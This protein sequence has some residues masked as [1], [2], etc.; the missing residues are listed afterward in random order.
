MGIF[1]RHQRSDGVVDPSSATTTTHAGHVHSKEDSNGRLRNP[2]QHQSESG[3]LNSRPP[4]GQWLKV[5]WPDIL[6]MICMGAIG[7]GVYKAHPAPSRSFPV[8]FQDGEI[9]YPEFAYP[10]RKELIPIWAAAM[11][12]ALVP[13]AVIL[14]CQLRV[15]SFWDVNNAV[16]GLLYSLINAA[17]FQVFLKWL[18]G[19]LRP[20][21]LAVCKPEIPPNGIETGNGL[22]EIFYDRSIC[23]GDRTQIDDSLES[24]PSGHTTA[25]FAGFVFLSLYLNAKLKVFANYH[26]A[27]W[28]LI[29]VYAPIL[30]ATL[31][32]GAL[33]IDKFHNWYDCFAGAVIGTLMAFSAYR[34][35][36][37]SV[38]DFRFNHIPLTRAVPFSFGA[39]PLGAGG[40]ESAVWTRQAE[41]GHEDGAFGGAPFDSAHALRGLGTGGA[42]SAAG[43]LSG[44]HD[45]TM[46]APHTST[47]NGHHSGV[48]DPHH[49][50]A[51]GNPAGTVN[52]SQT[53]TMNEPHSG[54]AVGHHHGN[55]IDR[56]PVG[57]ATG[58]STVAG[59]YG[60]HN[61]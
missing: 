49:G 7:L 60:D 50:T 23:T 9:V 42:S 48:N 6:T 13:I 34:M 51:H 1:S 36:Y 52:P 45:G 5:T 54:M 26:P 35:V 16:I 12:A 31:I 38:W 20:H 33:T 53:G 10:L 55:S 30:G 22:R 14:I 18:I 4:F 8:Y 56:R 47:L 24:F 57:A 44:H 37:A 40:F 32:G 41:W 27:F 39:G 11:L 3:H 29:A 19:G 61:V 21:F 58:Q 17:V 46:N 25:A 2:G 43:V 15:R 59:A 28:K